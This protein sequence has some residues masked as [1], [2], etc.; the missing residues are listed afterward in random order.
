M[1]LVKE[2]IHI[3]MEETTATEKSLSEFIKFHLFVYFSMCVCVLFFFEQHIKLN[4]SIHTHT[5]QQKLKEK[6]NTNI[7]T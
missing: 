5:H 3:K 4:G 7:E 6:T 2:N 1:F